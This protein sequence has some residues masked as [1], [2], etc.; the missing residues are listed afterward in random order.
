MGRLLLLFIRIYQVYLL[1]Y[2]GSAAHSTCVQDDDAA[3]R[4]V[5]RRLTD[6]ASSLDRC[7]YGGGFANVPAPPI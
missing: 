6:V 1:P 2:K 4:S 5:S 7:C 3:R